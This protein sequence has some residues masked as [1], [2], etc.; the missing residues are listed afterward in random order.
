MECS[1]C[2]LA[3]SGR[4][5]ADDVLACFL[6]RRLP[7]FQSATIVRSRDPAVLEQCDILVDVGA[8]YDPAKFRFDHHQRSFAETLGRAYKTKLSSAGLVYR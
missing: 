8:V 2:W 1:Y 4:F 6:L 7:E 3:Y 5:H